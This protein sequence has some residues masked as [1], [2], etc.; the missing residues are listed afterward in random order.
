MPITPIRLLMGPFI[1]SLP[2]PMKKEPHKIAKKAIIKAIE[3]GE[4][5]KKEYVALIV[6]GVNYPRP[7]EKYPPFGTIPDPKMHR[8]YF[9]L[10]L[11]YK[12]YLL[13]ND[14]V[15][16]VVVFD[17]LIGEFRAFKKGDITNGMVQKPLH[18]ALVV[19]KNYR[20]NINGK[21]TLTKPPASVHKDKRR[22]LYYTGLHELAKQLTGKEDG[23]VD[24][25]DYD[26]WTGAKENSMSV[27]DLYEKIRTSFAASIREVHFIGHAWTGG[28][29]I[30]NTLG[31]NNKQYDKDCRVKDFTNRNLSHVFDAKN[32][33]IFQAA[34]TEGAIITVWGCENS[35]KARQ[36]IQAAKDKKKMKKP[37][38]EELKQLQIM[39]NEETYAAALAKASQRVVYAA[40]PGT[41]S[42]H[43]GENN[44]D[45]SGFH[46][47]PTVMHVNLEKGERILQFY[48]THF[49]IFFPT[50]GAFKGHPIFGRGYAKYDPNSKFNIKS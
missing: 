11:N 39:L 1:R 17:F 26:P 3:K 47:V 46:F 24:K 20:F 29:I 40:L 41:Y 42:V 2:R 31:Y 18:Q 9:K 48:N 30:V 38:D 25:K 13:E 12:N 14:L 49:D 8:T 19:K 45:A 43:E 28:P 5:V 27:S 36:L 35:S 15:N 4:I 22:Q 10:A 32:L 16:L 21:L 7:E 50:T 6:A 23:D 33:P 34:F 37:I 44:D